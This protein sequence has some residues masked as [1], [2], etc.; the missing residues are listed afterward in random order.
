VVIVGRI[1]Y[2][3]NEP[4]ARLSV[5][6]ADEVAYEIVGP[7]AAELAQHQGDTLRLTGRH[8]E[9]GVL[10]PRFHVTSYESADPQERSSS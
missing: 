9:D 1:V 3:G 7:L 6:T 10:A 2:I 5:I 8:T 4:F